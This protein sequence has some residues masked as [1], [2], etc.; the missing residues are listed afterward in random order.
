MNN[1]GS[2]VSGTNVRYIKLG[3]KGE[4]EHE[5]TENGTLRFGFYTGQDRIL[6]LCCSEKWNEL[7]NFW[8]NEEQVSASTATR[9]TN[10][11]RKYFGDRGDTLWITF[12]EDR[13]YWGFLDEPL[14][15]PIPNSNSSYRKLRGGWR[16]QDIRGNDLTKWNLS[17]AITKLAA[18]RGTSC[19]VD[20][21]EKVI[22]RINSEDSKQI[23]A[24]REQYV[25]VCE[26][27]VPLIKSLHDKD[28]E[29]LIDLIFASSGWR[30]VSKVGGTQKTTDLDLLLPSTGERAFVQVKSKTDQGTF[31]TYANKMKDTSAD[32]M[33]F[34]YHTGKITNEDND[35]T[36]LDGDRIA[37]MAVNAG[38]TEWIMDKAS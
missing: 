35:I 20:V 18:Y 25:K 32:R 30:R 21:G 19:A 22:A 4:W 37:Q 12:V 15:K 2:I 28:F 11:T 24:A 38:L 31:K 6:Q 10:E 7:H 17:G 13:L 3:E 27:I 29:N 23:K 16:H 1:Q 5:C 36:P 9:F 26:A 14:P 33:F 34:A 8:L